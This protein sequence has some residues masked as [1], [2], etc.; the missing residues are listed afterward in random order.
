MHALVEQI[1]GC[2]WLSYLNIKEDL[3]VG[4]CQ[5]VVS[6][7]QCWPPLTV[8]LPER[9]PL[10]LVVKDHWDGS[11]QLYLQGTFC[12]TRLLRLVLC[13]FAQLPS[14]DIDDAEAERELEEMATARKVGSTEQLVV[15][16]SA[17]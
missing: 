12:L 7:I 15:A 5:G 2:V 11:Y 13:F 8:G 16:G 17:L 14:L 10:G 6:L 1:S 3:P 9:Q 4:G